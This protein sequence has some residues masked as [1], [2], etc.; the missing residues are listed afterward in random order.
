M[1][2]QI[3]EKTWQRLQARANAQNLSVDE[4]LNDLLDEANAE[5]ICNDHM[6]DA[7]P[8]SILIT[9]ARQ[10]D[11][12]IVFANATFEQVTGY[13]QDE[14]LGYNCRFLQND[15][16][17]Q[18]GIDQIRSAVER[19][20]SCTVLLRNYRKDGSMFWNELR[21]APV[22]DATGQLTHFVGI[23][24]DVTERK[25]IEEEL[26]KSETRLRSLLESQSAFV[27]RTD[28]NGEYTYVNPAFVSWYGWEREKLL[29]ESVLETIHVLDHEK[30]ER[31]VEAC[32]LQPG[33]PFQVLLRKIMPDRGL[34][35][36]LWEFMGI[37]DSS[38][39]VMEI[40]CVGFDI[41]KQLEL[42]EA[43]QQSEARYRTAVESSL[44]AF[45][46]LESVRD[47]ITGDVIDF[48]IVEVNEN[49]VQQM[50]LSRTALVNGLICELFP[51]NRTG[52]FFEQY[53]HVVETEH[54]FEQEY[55]IPADHAAPG[56]YHHQVVKVGDGV[57]IVNRDITER[58]RSEV[59]LR[60]SE[61]KYRL[62]VENSYQGIMI[63][64]VDPI[65]ISFANQAIE[66]IIGYTPD[67]MLSMDRDS[68]LAI[69]HPDDREAFV[70][71]LMDCIQGKETAPDFRVQIYRK[72]GEFRYINVNR[73]LITY[74]EH[75]AVQMTFIDVTDRVES[76]R[77]KSQFRVE[78]ERNALIQR[79]ISM[80]SHDLRT[81]LA[82]IAS[83]RDLLVRYHDR[84]SAKKRQE[85]LDTIG[86]QVQFATELLEDTV[87]M[88]RSPLTARKFE[89]RPVNLATLCQVSVDEV[90]SI[91]NGDY[92]INC[93]NLGHVKT[94]AVDE[95]LVSRIFLNLLSNAIKYSPV[96][97]QIRLELDRSDEWIILRVIDQ[98]MGISED[99]LPHIFDPFYRADDAHHINGTGLG[100]NIVKDCVDRHE[101]RIHVESKLG[102]G[103]VFTVELPMQVD[104]SDQ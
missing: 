39:A 70:Q 55:M 102:Q 20:E 17:D 61:E 97:G 14:T 30:T 72:N 28:M 45:Y 87:N 32:I 96:G 75:P 56:W 100:L 12:P 19:G 66:D 74:E 29:S 4:L 90:R 101:G 49:A 13:S 99:D 15:D 73:V 41:T 89:P 1:S 38:G 6:L 64:Q 11:H 46:L 3:D 60:T 79:I 68:L 16:R 86:R 43:L 36:T 83:S 80:L 78:Q 47:D 37:Q 9:D 10:P 23:Q 103:S 53:K 54:P 24:N 7:A 8:S 33:Q 35:H 59:M 27:I 98:G 81:P 91:H 77:L 84:L 42:E 5:M 48:R 76:E 57:A 40:Q 71:H 58:K 94:V 104:S 21:I 92:P 69:T 34:R 50:G 31:I 88:A 25:R 93:T 63:E 26:L 2:R 67:E 52:G 18:P 85:K 22:R 82:V 95:V 44:D 65:R 62:L 51:I